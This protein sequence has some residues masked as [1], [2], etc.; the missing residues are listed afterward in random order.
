MHAAYYRPGGVYRDLPDTMP[1][2]T[3][4]RANTAAR[5][6]VRAMNDA[7]S[8]SLLLD[9]IEDF[10]NRFP[11]AS[12]STKRCSPT[13]ASGS[14]A[15]WG[16][17]WSTRIAPRRWASRPDAARLGRGL[18]PA[19]DA[20]LRSLRSDGLRRAGRRQMAI[21]TTAIWCAWPRCA[22]ANRIIRQCVEWLRNNP[23]R[24]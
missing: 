20:T 3:A 12:T 15:W 24:S 19:Q 13:T 1:Q 22:K 23:V 17:A 10:T 8:G 14:S 4:I 7:R 2:Y 5:K 6:E 21:A 9:F 16:S 11:A 18:G